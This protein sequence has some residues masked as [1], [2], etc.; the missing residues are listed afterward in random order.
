VPEA[1]DPGLEACLVA[2]LRPR[3]SLLLLD[4]V[5]KVVAAA[6]LMADLLVQCPGLRV[7][8]TSRVA[9]RVQGEH[10]FPVEPLALPDP[11]R[12]PTL[13]AAAHSPALA[14]F[15]Q[16]AQA[17]RPDFALDEENVAAVVD[18]CQRLDGLPLALEL[19]AP[20]L[21][22]LSA[23][24]LLARLERRLSVLAGGARDLPARQQTLRATLD[25][26]YEL[27]TPDEQALFARLGVF[28]GGCTLEAAETVCN[29]DGALDVLGEVASLVDKSLLRMEDQ[30]VGEPRLALLETIHEYALEQLA[31]RGEEVELR[32]RHSGYYLALAEATEPAL[33]WRPA[34]APPVRL[35]QEHDNLRA[36]LSWALQ[37]SAQPARERQ[38]GTALWRYRH[39]HGHLSEG[40]AWLE[41]LLAAN[42]TGADSL[43][44]ARA[45]A[46][47]AAAW[48]AQSQDDFGRAAVLFE[49]SLTLHRT[50]EQAE[51]L[52][53]LLINGA[54]IAV[55]RG[56]YGRAREL[57]EES[58]ARHRAARN[59]QSIGH[60]GLGLSLYRLGMVL[61]VQGDY[62][63]ALTLTEE[64]LALH[65]TLQDREG[66]AIALLGLGDIARDQD[67]VA[68]VR[69]SCAESLA[70]FEELGVSWGVGFAL[71]NLAVA[72]E[73]SGELE[74]ALALAERSVSLF[75]ELG[76]G[77]TLCEV[78]TTL[79]RIAQVLGDG[80]RARAVLGEALPLAWAKGPR[81]V[82]AA[83]L[84][85]LA[86]LDIAGGRAQ[87]GAQLCGAAAGLR[88]SMRAPLPP[89]LRPSYE[90]AL[91]DARQALGQEAVAAALATGDA[92]PLELA[93][94]MALAAPA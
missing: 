29:A 41:R 40:R 51:G 20:R 14:L 93:I 44:A 1:Q 23:Q 91:A 35:E 87:R 89:L 7:L 75:R 81:W 60:G 5:E 86:T 27:L 79:A 52:T 32:S 66:T 85:E 22:L 25:W 18:I 38:P 30:P 17:V 43:A 36:A 59:Q 73:R 19:A 13:A 84:E 34:A 45:T 37:S 58:L 78:L 2:T 53:D 70:L 24:A 71:N 88:L 83:A 47:A 65:R 56:D 39:L 77:I 76:V 55:A 42:G 31:A 3:R 69:A 21:R 54:L 94:G 28:V 90:R 62:A 16:R 8:A 68:R 46:L 57:L 4:N 72:A 49:Q 11:T 80:P 74:Q 15:V 6:P 61:R 9:L 33:S 50:L 82:V 92:M 67:D 48:T 12:P 63:R 64:C 26:S 10:L